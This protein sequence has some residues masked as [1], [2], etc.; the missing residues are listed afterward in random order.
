MARAGRW[1][2]GLDSSK[3]GR[4]F[5]SAVNGAERAGM[6]IRGCGGNRHYV[7][8]GKARQRDAGKMARWNWPAGCV[9]INRGRPT[10]RA[11]LGFDDKKR[12][13]ASVNDIDIANSLG[14][15][16]GS[17][18]PTDED[19]IAAPRLAAGSQ[20]LERLD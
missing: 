20:A 4:Q 17:P 6:G 19:K 18:W 15:L 10:G 11:G 8:I 2:A 7:T 9:P 16:K 14:S 12:I 3:V 13:G 1:P 5:F